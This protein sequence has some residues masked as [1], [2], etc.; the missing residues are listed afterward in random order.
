MKINYTVTERFIKYAKIDTQSDPNSPTCPSTE[1]QKDLARVLVQEMLEM[2]ISD[3]HMD[4]NGYVYGTIPA[5]T[6]KKV[7]VI[8]F[9][10]HM[11]TSPDCSGKDVNPQIHKNYDGKDIVLPNDKTQVIKVSE[12]P[13][14]LKQIGNDIITTDGTTLLGADNKAGVAEIMDAANHL[15]KHPEIKHGTIKILFTPDE[16][17]GR[18]ADK[19]DLKK[20]GA[21]YGY[22]IDGE[23]LGHIENETFS[24]DGVTIKIHGVSTHPGFA[25]NKMESAIKIASEIVAALPKDKMSP[26]STEKKEPFVHPVSISGGIEET[27]LQFIIR[28]FD[29]ESLKTQEDFLK[30]LTEKVIKNYPNSSFDFIVKE[31][32]RNMKQVLDKNPAIV[33]NAMEAVR[34]AGV[35]PVLSSIRGGTDGSRFSYMGLPCPNIFAGEHAFHSKHEWVSVQ[36]M[37]RAVDTIVNLSIIWE[38]RA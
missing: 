1:K 20:L 30:S 15:M 26:E 18:G 23:E 14:L 28:A 12:H 6:T 33:D 3:A 5:N 35:T 38:E 37:H 19:A 32:Y 25:K 21:D 22:T 10:S 17:I 36:D 34:R 31:Q 24:A 11:D 7:P 8:C 4:E 29:E 27:V 9:C 2:G 13:S 16:E